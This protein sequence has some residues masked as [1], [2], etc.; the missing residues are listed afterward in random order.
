MVSVEAG[1]K[2]VIDIEIIKADSIEKSAEISSLDEKRFRLDLPGAEKKKT[3]Q[4]PYIMTADG[5]ENR[6]IGDRPKDNSYC[7]PPLHC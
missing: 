3:P 6:V 1:T 5:G 2:V 4:T 7:S